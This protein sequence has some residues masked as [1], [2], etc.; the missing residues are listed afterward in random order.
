MNGQDK[1]ALDHLIVKERSLLIFNEFCFG[2]KCQWLFRF[3]AEAFVGLFDRVSA[4]AFYRITH[5]NMS[6][7]AY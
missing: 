3:L 6:L 4:V 7:L 1:G 2:G 5:V